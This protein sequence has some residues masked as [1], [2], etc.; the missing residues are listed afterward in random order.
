M[1]DLTE[2][3][4][5]SPLV[6]LFTDEDHHDPT[7][8]DFYRRVVI[9]QLRATLLCELHAHPLGA[10]YT[11]TTS[12]LLDV[13]SGDLFKYYGRARGA[14]LNRLVRQNIFKRI[15]EHWKD[16][17][18][19]IQVVNDELQITWH[20]SGEKEQFLSWLEDKRTRFGTGKAVQ[21]Q[22]QDQVPKAQLTLDLVMPGV[23]QSDVAD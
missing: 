2:E 21:E 19:G 11:R 3:T 23:E 15:E 1:S 17:Q 20:V 5:P 8:Q 6:L 14:S 10:L 18:P 16:R 9:E 4:N 7:M 22:E 13:T 12:Q